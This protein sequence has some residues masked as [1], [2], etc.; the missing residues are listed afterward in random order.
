MVIGLLRDSRDITEV[1]APGH[2]ERLAARRV[3]L[4]ETIAVFDSQIVAELA[5]RLGMAR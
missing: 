5:G 2:A 3:F 4:S 1:V